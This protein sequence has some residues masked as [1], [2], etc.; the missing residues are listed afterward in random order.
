[1]NPKQMV[2]LACLYACV[3]ILTLTT[4]Q[5]NTNRTYTISKG[6][7]ITKP[8][9]TKKC[10]NITVPYPFGIGSDCAFNMQFELSCNTSDDG[11]Q[12][13]ILGINIM[14]YD[15]SDTEL[16]VENSISWRCY[17]SSGAV[18]D[19][20][21]GWTR[22]IDSS[23]YSFSVLNRFTIVGCDDYGSI[24]VPN[25]FEYGCNVSCTSRG[26][27]IEGE[28]MGKGCGQKHIPKGL[29]YYNTTMSSTENHTDVWSFNSCGYAFLGEADRFRF[30]G[31]PDLGDDLYASYFYDRI[32]ASVPIVLD[33]AIGS[34]TCTQ[35]LKIENYACSEN[36][37]CIDSDTGLGG[38]R[39]SCNTGYHGNPYL[40]QGCQGSYNCSC[41]HGYTGDGKKDGRGC[42]APS[43]KQFPWIKFSLGWCLYI[44]SGWNN[45]V[46]FQNQEKEID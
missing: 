4:A 24:T 9:C 1:M 13:L 11:S 30:Q 18:I 44:P 28:C 22:F 27:V 19:E 5:T 42:I 33:W 35:A 29:K 16:R 37:H 12:K 32:Q 21:L 6:D 46:L 23:P 8:G 34:L 10:G 40:N 31:L 17:N 45:L 25:N 39:C 41:P 38:Y 14:V 7:N 20:S 15:I 36:S 26:D 2:L 43:S 3:L